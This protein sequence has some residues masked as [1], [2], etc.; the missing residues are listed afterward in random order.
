MPRRVALRFSAALTAELL[1]F[2]ALNFFDD[3]SLP[4]MPVKFVAVAIGCGMAYLIA[5]SNLPAQGPSSARRGGSPGQ[6]ADVDTRKHILP[7]FW[8]VTIVLRLIALPMV[9]GDDIWRY[10]WEGK[11][12]NAGFNPY[13]S[14]PA[15]PELAPL[16]K[17]FPNWPQIN[18]REFPAIYPPGTEIVFAIMSRI[19]KGV[20]PYKILFALADLATV[21][22]L[23]RLL[24]GP[25][26]FG[27]AACYAWN[28]MVAY[29]FAGAAHFDSLMLLPMIG[30]LLFLS[31]H[32]ASTE[33]RSQWFWAL[34]AAAALG[35]AISIKLIPALLLLV[36]VFALGRRAVALIVSAAIPALLALSYGFPRTRIW[37]S[38]GDFIYVTRLNDFFWWIVED[39]F[40]ANP[41][42]K[43]YHYN[44]II[45]VVVAIV[46]VIFY[47]NWKRGA[48][49]S[50]RI[51]AHPE[52]GLPPMVLHL[53]FAH[54]D[55]A[56]RPCLACSFGDALCLLSFLES[57]AFCSSLAQRGLA[58][59]PHHWSSAGLHG[60][61][62]RT[63]AAFSIALGMTGRAG[64]GD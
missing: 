46:S 38:L 13:V 32:E 29:S 14:E 17:E 42:Q 7:I 23:L 43:N 50:P 3:W 52:P 26:R 10:Q 4:W 15:A 55:L 5:V 61:P 6:R 24:G 34:A 63:T 28:P 36:F 9:P 11:I 12:Q 40:W 39:T 8:I 41:H 18:H 20:L 16:R 30:A 2:G 35:C 37:E 57:A 60:L 53:D 44:V 19:S 62:R 21:G 31:R 33:N 45:L 64:R 22:L 51:G 25:E 56:A 54:R 47:R 48:L 49:W 58:A 1:L 59:R 27:Q